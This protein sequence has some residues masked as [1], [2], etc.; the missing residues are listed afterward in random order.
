M[1]DKSESFDIKECAKQSE[2]LKS[3]RRNFE[4]SFS[5]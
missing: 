5:C 1:S 4:Q 2:Y 3:K